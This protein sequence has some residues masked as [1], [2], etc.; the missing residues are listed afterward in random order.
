MSAAEAFFDQRDSGIQTEKRLEL[1]RRFTLAGFADTTRFERI[2][3]GA[4]L[5][6]L[7]DDDEEFAEAELRAGT[8]AARRGENVY[9]LNVRTSELPE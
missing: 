3:N 2:P 5:F 7:P 4:M 9:F 1:V 6:L 8:Q